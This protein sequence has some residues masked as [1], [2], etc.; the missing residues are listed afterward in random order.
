MLTVQQ[1]RRYGAATKFKMLSD[2]RVGIN[3]TPSITNSKLEVGGAD[4]VPL[5]NVEASGNTGGIGIGSNGLQLFHGTS[6][7]VTI[8]SDGE[9]G[10]GTNPNAKFHVYDAGGN[11]PTIRITRG[12]DGGRIQFQYAS[13]TSGFGEIGQTYYGTGRTR[14]W[15]GANLESFST[16]HLGP[17]QQDASYGSW[18]STW[19]SYNDEFTINRISSAS[20]NQMVTVNYLGRSWGK[21]WTIHL[22]F[23]I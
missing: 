19:D 18:F 1:N 10:I 15:M 8:N 22:H 11:D 17:T 5:I 14:I 21:Y 12:L 7:K 9:L 2:G 4:D 3:R 6:S 13:N 16:A 20:N 23:F